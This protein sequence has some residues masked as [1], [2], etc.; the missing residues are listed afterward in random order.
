MVIDL[1]ET[2]LHAHRRESQHMAAAQEDAHPHPNF[3]ADPG[4]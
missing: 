3:F 4:K 1:V 2:F